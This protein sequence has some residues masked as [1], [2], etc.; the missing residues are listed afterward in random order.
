MK[1]YKILIFLYILYFFFTL[2]STLLLL[3]FAYKKERKEHFTLRVAL[4]K[5]VDKEE[6]RESVPTCDE[7]KVGRV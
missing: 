5:K 7:S 3:S 2:I 4:R 1:S 6:E